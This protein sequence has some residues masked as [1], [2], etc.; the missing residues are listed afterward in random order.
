M[1]TDDGR[2]SRQAEILP[3]AIELHMVKEN[4]SDAFRAAQLK[5]QPPFV[6]RREEIAFD[7][8][9]FALFE[10]GGEEL[11]ADV[12]IP[13]RAVRHAEA[14]ADRG[15]A[16]RI[17]FDFHFGP[18]KI[19]ARLE[20]DVLQDARIVRIGEPCAGLPVFGVGFV[21][22]ACAEITAPEVPIICP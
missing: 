22:A 18:H 19:Q 16:L 9:P 13:S 21:H 7:F 10:I 3:Y 5:A 14:H 17:A 1:S 8:T 15:D 4:L 6:L 12:I 20:D 2:L 11:G